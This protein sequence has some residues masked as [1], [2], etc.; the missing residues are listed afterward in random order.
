MSTNDVNKLYSFLGEINANNSSNYKLEVLKKYKDSELVKRV[1]KMTYC[2]VDYNYGIGKTTLQKISILDEMFTNNLNIISAL[3]FLENKLATR[4][5][6]GHAAVNGLLEVFE[7]I[8]IQDRNIIEKVL[9]RDLRLNIGR[10]NILKVFKD[11]IVK[12]SYMRCD[13][14]TKK[15]AK[16]IQYPAP[17]QKKVDGTYREFSIDDGEVE[18]RS[19]SGESYNYP[20]HNK[21]LSKLKDGV[22]VGELTVRASEE[23]MKTVFEKLENAKRRGDDTE[24]LEDIISKYNEYKLLDTEYILPR[25]IGNGLI[26]SDEPPHEDIVIEL[27]DYITFEEYNLARQ[28]DK[29]KP[30]TTIYNDRFNILKK[31][32]SE[33]DYKDIRIIEHVIVNNPHEVMLQNKIWME[34]GYEGSILKDWSGVFKDGTSNKQ[35]KIKLKISAEMRII[36]FLDGTIGTKRE[37]KVGSIIFKNDE[38]TIEGRCSG[39]TDD[40]LDELTNNKENYLGKIIEVEFNDLSRAS[41]SEVYALSH[42]RFICTREKDETDTLEQVFKM[43][44]MAMDVSSY[45]EK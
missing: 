37:G 45:F 23:T 18:C 13:V 34:K 5:L 32:I 10:T 42:P 6:T 38:G 22:Y 14:L 15:T 44:E 16:N 24:E 43:R 17:L 9:E 7:N 11:L 8:S 33:I 25:G 31:N 35:L 30:C 29:K 4:I 1:L 40:F 3:D 19:R 27:W 36:G 21:Y 28:K 39:F 12:P 26:N 41:G 2:K 20:L